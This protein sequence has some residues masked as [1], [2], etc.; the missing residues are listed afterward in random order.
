MAARRGAWSA[1]WLQQ[2]GGLGAQVARARRRAALRQLPRAHALAAVDRC[3]GRALVAR[4]RPPASRWSRG[5]GSSGIGWRGWSEQAVDHDLSAYQE[6]AARP[7][8]RA[9]GVPQRADRPD[10]GDQSHSVVA[11]LPGA[12]GA[13][14]ASPGSGWPGPGITASPRGRS[15]APPAPF[16]AF[17][18]NDQL[19]WGWVA[20]AR[21]GAPPGARA[22]AGSSGANLLLVLGVLYAARG[23]A[24]VLA[25]RGRVAAIRSIAVL[26]AHRDV[27][28][29]VRRGRAHAARARGHLA[30]F[31]A[32]AVDA[33]HLRV[34]PMIEVI[35]REDV[36]SLGKAGEMVRVKPGYAR[37]YLLPRAWPTRPPRAT[38]SASRRK[39]R[40]RDQPEP[41]RARRGR[42]RSPRRWARVTLTLDGQ[43][44]RGRQAVRLDHRPGHR[45]GA[46]QA[47]GT[48]V[49]RRRIEL[50]HPIK[51]LGH[52]T[53]GVR[54]HP[55]VHA[56]VRVSVVA[57]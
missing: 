56:E 41:G 6:A 28:V 11:A 32:S 5:C 53:V 26:G 12:A 47:R 13:S 54:L 34:R 29:A 46:G 17:R 4:R 30:R 22:L 20:G 37:N 7:S 25:R 55:E 52:H 51:T 36:K 44:R 15:G 3:S 33:G 2:V 57:E 45:R 18:F 35:L 50:E 38:R 10:D 31:P 14:P 24:V 48:Q 19:V 1:L 43:G 40:A 27:S 16:P 23:L 8:G 42:A 39:T 49:D 9:A 21:A